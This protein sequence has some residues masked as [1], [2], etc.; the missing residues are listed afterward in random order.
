[1]TMQSA[2][3]PSKDG[4]AVEPLRPAAVETATAVV[5]V[6]GRL[7]SWHPVVGLPLSAAA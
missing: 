3:I 5:L 7:M 1:M 2:S 4:T 6:R